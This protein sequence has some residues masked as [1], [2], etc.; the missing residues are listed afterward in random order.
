MSKYDRKGNENFNEF[1]N[2][3]YRPKVNKKAK[4]KPQ[5]SIEEKIRLAKRGQYDRDEEDV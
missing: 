2:S 3:L 5:R 4:R 1:E